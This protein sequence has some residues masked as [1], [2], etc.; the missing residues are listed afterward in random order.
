MKIAFLHTR[1]FFTLELLQGLRTTLAHDEVVEWRGGKDAPAFDFDVLLAMGNVG[2]E[3][4][5]DQ[6]KLKLIQTASVGYEE[7]DIDA[8]SELGIW[9]SYSGSVSAERSAVSVAIIR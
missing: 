6:P 2:R 7:V 9:V 5:L 8:T 3:L 4:L 1:N